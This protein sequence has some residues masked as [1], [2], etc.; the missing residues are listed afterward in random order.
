MTP[1][2]SAWTRFAGAVLPHATDH[3]PA[4]DAARVAAECAD[5]AL[6]E[7]RKRR[8]A[9]AF[10]PQAHHPD[11]ETNAEILAD[12][13]EARAIDAAAGIRDGWHKGPASERELESKWL[14]AVMK[15][16]AAERERDEQR[17][18]AEAA[19]KDRGEWK[20]VAEGW[21][22]GAGVAC[23]RADKAESLL[24]EALGA[25][26]LVDYREDAAGD[27]D[28]LHRLNA[29]MVATARAVLSKAKAAGY[30]P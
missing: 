27:R 16:K 12:L 20:A 29:A 23:V 1:D 26:K 6:A 2:E 8:E 11:P 7:L 9:G 14:Q 22:A 30:E 17:A 21:A 25:L 5:A 28:T 18:R 3:N 19:E 24:K 10:G 4:A 13:A 15:L